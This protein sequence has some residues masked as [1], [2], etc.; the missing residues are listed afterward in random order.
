VKNR[1][2][3]PPGHRDART[4]ALGGFAP[5][6]FIYFLFLL[7]VLSAAA[8]AVARPLD[9][10]KESGELVLC[11]HPNAL[12]FSKKDGPRHGF[13]LE[14]GAALAK[15][16]GVALRPSWITSPYDVH[17]ADCD[18]L[19]DAID[20]PAALAEDHLRLS[21]PYRRGGVVL[22]VPAADRAIAGLGDLG[23]NTRVAILP[24][25]LVA[26]VLD[27]RH[28]PTTPA[29]FEDELL[30]EVATG[31]AAAAAVT[32]AAIGYYNL[33]HP[34]HPMRAVDAFAGDPDLHWNIAIAM[35]RPDAALIA[36]VNA[37]L[38]KLL[39]AGTVKAIYARYGVTLEPPR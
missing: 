28:V 14:L 27:R 11:A 29:L 38:A 30:G 4:L 10:V 17:R 39:A 25:S 19:L 35:I 15:A 5:W 24:R 36:A 34:A 21:A 33:T 2:C 12:P 1:I 23:R 31:E 8:P 37:A 26:M 6:G 16:M 22:A 18:L 7:A 20:D 9:Q 13:Q 32:P 3:K